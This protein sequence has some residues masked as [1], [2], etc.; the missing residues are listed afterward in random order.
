MLGMGVDAGVRVD[1]VE[2][3]VATLRFGMGLLL[4]ELLAELYPAEDTEAPPV[5]LPLLPAV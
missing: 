4:A 1:V 2:A 5:T 3:G